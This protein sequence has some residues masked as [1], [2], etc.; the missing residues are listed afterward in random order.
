MG[1]TKARKEE[2][3]EK[4]LYKSELLSVSQKA[5]NS[6]DEQNIRPPNPMTGCFFSLVI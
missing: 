5:A 3:R 6:Q 4:K 2:E 1:R